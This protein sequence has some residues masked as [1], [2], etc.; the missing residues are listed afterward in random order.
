MDEQQEAVD[1]NVAAVQRKLGERS[2]IGLDKYGVD[3][4][5]QDLGEVEWLNHLQLELMDAAVYIEA[6]L[7][8]V[9]LVIEADMRKSTGNTY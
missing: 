8:S 7:S 1:P 3:T 9:S 4:T 5:R 2:V 6:L